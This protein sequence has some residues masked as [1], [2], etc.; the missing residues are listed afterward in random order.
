MCICQLWLRSGEAETWRFSTRTQATFIRTQATFIP[1]VWDRKM[2]M[3]C[4]AWDQLSFYLSL[5]VTVCLIL[6]KVV[7]FWG[8]YFYG[9]KICVYTPVIIRNWWLPGMSNVSCCSD[10]SV[11]LCSFVDC[12]GVGWSCTVCLLIQSKLS[13]Q[14][15]NCWHG[16]FSSNFS[17]ISSERECN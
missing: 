7:Q 6:T 9:L 15:Y 17:F 3:C 12:S 11:Y 5:V 8:L 10:K 2:P 16:I 14:T 4:H 13:M 1:S